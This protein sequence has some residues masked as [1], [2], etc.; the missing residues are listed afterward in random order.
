MA[1]Q[2]RAAKVVTTTFE[3]LTDPYPP[4]YCSVRYFSERF[5]TLELVV[6]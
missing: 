1:R 5:E 3:R 2:G 6:L 4:A